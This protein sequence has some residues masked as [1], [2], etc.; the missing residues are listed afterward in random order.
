MMVGYLENFVLVGSTETMGSGFG[1][2]FDPATLLKRVDANGDGKIS[3]AEYDGFVKLL[4][5]F[6]DNPDEARRLFVRLDTDGDGFIIPMEFQKLGAAG[7]SNAL[8][9][10]KEGSTGPSPSMLLPYNGNVDL[11][12]S[13]EH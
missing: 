8:R 10:Q 6:K 12:Y 13:L 9:G 3:R 7:L 2:R 5:R 1:G 11:P 4:P